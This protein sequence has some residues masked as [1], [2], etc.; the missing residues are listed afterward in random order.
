VDKDEEEDPCAKMDGVEA[1]HRVVDETMFCRIHLR[2]R[3]NEVC[4]TR[5][6]VR[7]LR[8]ERQ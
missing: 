2:V 7:K 6:R 3:E 8:M 5:Q 4:S 1:R